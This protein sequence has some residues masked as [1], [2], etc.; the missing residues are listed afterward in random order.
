MAFIE[1]S[2][3]AYSVGV[4]QFDDEHKELVRLINEL[5]AAMKSGHGRD[6][7]APTLNSLTRYVKLHFTREETIMGQHGYPGLASQRQ[8]H[9]GFVKRLGEYQKNFDAGEIGITVDLLQFLQSWL[10]DHILRTDRQY[11]A[12][13][14]AKGVR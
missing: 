9:E 8:Q 6:V 1:W 2:D 5:H 3:A 4:K 7:M 13:F 14:E 10:L 12:F 11:A